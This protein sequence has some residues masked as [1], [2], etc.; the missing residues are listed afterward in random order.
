MKTKLCLIIGMVLIMGLIV[1]LCGCNGKNSPEPEKYVV[2]MKFKQPEYKNFILANYLD[3]SSNLVATRFNNCG[4][5]KGKSG[6]SPYWEL[7]NDWLL[8]D[9]K[10][11]NFP[12]DAGLTLLTEQTWDKLDNSGTL[13]LPNWPL[14]EPHVFQPVEKIDYVK[15]TKLQD[16]VNAKYS[17]EVLGLSPAKDSLSICEMQDEMDRIWSILQSDLSTAIKNGD[18]DKLRQ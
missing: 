5:P 4:E 17:T 9:W 18:L 13:P 3:G 11:N 10:W 1:G 12:Y 16:Y 8:V 6:S 7:P 14:T 15:I 2:I